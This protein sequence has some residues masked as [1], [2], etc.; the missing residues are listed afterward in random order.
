MFGRIADIDDPYT[1]R[2][3]R[4]FGLLFAVSSLLQ[5]MVDPSGRGASAQAVRAC[6]QG[7]A[8]TRRGV[9]WRP[10]SARDPCCAE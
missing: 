5:L 10:V 6:H 3:S 4:D 1:D 8:P 9:R 7:R 2:E